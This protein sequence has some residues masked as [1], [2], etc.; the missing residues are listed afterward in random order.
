MAKDV[1][2]ESIKK[3]TKRYTAKTFYMNVSEAGQDQIDKINE[4]KDTASKRRWVAKN[5]K[6]K[7]PKLL[8]HQGE[9][10]QFQDDLDKLILVI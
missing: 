6:V 3:V 10:K 9:G 1:E 8:I 5:M 2:E 4:E 7:D